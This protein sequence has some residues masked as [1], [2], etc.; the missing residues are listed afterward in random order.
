V[1]IGVTKDNVPN[2]KATGAGGKAYYS[3]D[4]GTLSI[5][6]GTVSATTGTAIYSRGNGQI[7]IEGGSVQSTNTTAPSA[8]SAATPSGTICLASTTSATSENLKIVTGIVYNGSTG[9]GCTI[10]VAYPTAMTSA[11]R[12]VTAAG[13]ITKEGS[14]STANSY[15]IW[16]AATGTVEITGGVVT[17]NKYNCN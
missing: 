7:T 11:P 6:R 12:R 15:A 1:V 9:S 13:T 5:I 8:H 10:Y 2:V 4:A 16:A 14:T 17:G 3:W